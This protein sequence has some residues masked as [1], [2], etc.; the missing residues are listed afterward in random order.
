MSLGG[1]KFAGKYCEKGSLTDAQWAHLM[2]ATKIA[3]FMAAN[4]LA[5]AGWEYDMS[6]SSDGNIHCL[7]SVGNNYVT[8]F[9]NTANSSYFAIYTLTCFGTSAD[10]GTGRI[11]VALTKNSLGT[12]TNHDVGTYASNFYRL[13]KSHIAYDADLSSSAAGITD[14]FPVGNMGA[15]AMSANTAYGKTNTLFA[16]SKNYY[17]YALKD[18][19]I[20]MLAGDARTASGLS[21]SVASTDA[22][23]TLFNS[24]DSNG[25]LCVNLQPRPGAL[26]DWYEADARVTD[27]NYSAFAGVVLTFDRSGANVNAAR[28]I[29]S[30]IALYSGNIQEYPYQN[31]IVSNVENT[32]TNVLSKGAINTDLLSINMQSVSAAMVPALLSPVANGNYLTVSGNTMANGDSN[33]YKYSLLNDLGNQTT[34]AVWITAYVGWDSD[35]PDITTDG[36]WDEYTEP[37]PPD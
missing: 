17:G 37:A 9:K 30:A 20:V 22:F 24:N 3:A 25:A 13:S 26:A 15:Q 12:A 32:A 10:A 14:L 27:S 28:L 16:D 2:H 23:S 31:L 34:P 36:A 4:T 1:Y 21:V 19:H 11:A 35:N 29:T 6:G 7:D 5:E 8:C 18:Q 33:F